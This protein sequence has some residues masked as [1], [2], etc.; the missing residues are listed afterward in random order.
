MGIVKSDLLKQFREYEYQ[1]YILAEFKKLMN[2][3]FDGNAKAA[4]KP[5][6]G[7]ID[8]EKKDIL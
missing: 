2:I 3:S 8:A 4:Y 1:N 5:A 6:L 7:Y